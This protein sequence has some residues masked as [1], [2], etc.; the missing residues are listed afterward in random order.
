[1]SEKKVVPIVFATD[2][3]YAPYL[4][5]ALHS[6]IVHAS[7]EY[8]Y[9]V[10]IFCTYVSE[11]HKKRMLAMETEQVRIQFLQI[12]KSTLEA[13]SFSSCN[14]LTVEATYRFLIAEVLPQYHKVL[15]LDCDIVILSDVAELYEFDVSDCV[16]GVAALP[17]EHEWANLSGKRLNIPT[18][19]LF[20][21]GVLLLNTKKFVSENIK[22]KSMRLLQE[23]WSRDE[24]IF[25]LQDQDALCVV[26]QGQTKRFPTVWNFEW[27]QEFETKKKAR[28]SSKEEECLYEETKNNA[29]IV[30][31]IT[32]K[33]PWNSPELPL[34]GLF[35][36]Y[37]RETVFYEEILIK[38]AR[39]KKRPKHHIF[40]WKYVDIGSEVVIYGGGGI[41]KRYIEQILA[42]PLC[43][44]AAICDQNA[45][46]MGNRLFPVVTIEE[47]HSVTFDYIVIAIEEESIAK[48]IEKNLIESGVAPEKIKW[49]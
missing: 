12:D 4:G 6:L 40:P 2:D 32:D 25:L 5:V 34:A 10:C 33:K 17:V 1:M 18:E 28:T 45:K 49:R 44:I 48:T 27:D 13:D 36:K 41:G 37:A 30:H 9:E 23:D 16:L 19:A 21:S 14:H 24:R 8:I 42:T 26:C 39:P 7:S 11:E 38:E 46:S 15:Y 31:Y 22:E 3:G 47:L 29:K 20:N 43:S 35:W